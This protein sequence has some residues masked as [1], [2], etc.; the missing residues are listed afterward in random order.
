M[1]AY[2]ALELLYSTLAQPYAR[3]HISKLR[4]LFLESGV[5]VAYVI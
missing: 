3:A 2:S 4:P 5:K 1:I